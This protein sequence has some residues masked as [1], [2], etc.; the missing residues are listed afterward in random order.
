MSPKT[1]DVDEVKALTFPDHH[2]LGEQNDARAKLQA[3]YGSTEVE[4][5]QE[6]RKR[7]LSPALNIDYGTDHPRDEDS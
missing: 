7:V 1:I 5:D 3:A 2:S 4:I 6:R